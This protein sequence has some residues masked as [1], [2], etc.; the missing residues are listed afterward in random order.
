RGN[1]SKFLDYIFIDRNNTVLTRNNYL[2]WTKSFSAYLLARGYIPKNPTEGLERI[3]SR[4]KKSRDVIPDCTMQLIRDYLMEHNR[5]YLL[6]CE[7]I[8]YLFIRPRE[9]SYLR[10]CD[11]HI[12]TQTLT[13]H[14]EN[15]KNGNDAVIT[16]PTHVIKLMLELNIFSHPGQDYLFSDGFMPGSERKNEKMFRDYWTRGL[17]K[18]LKLSP[19]FKFYSLKDTGITNMLRAN[20]DV[21]SVRDQAR[22]SSI[23]ITD[24]YTPKDI[25]KANE[26]IKNYQGIL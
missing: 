3:K 24:I 16:L 14:G 5:H 17:R 13:L 1:V 19:R 26:Y 22:H 23:L 6:A 20:A 10:I 18:E 8:H 7:I 12:K 11:I 9:M 4:Q 21:L 15:T 25:Q 2:A